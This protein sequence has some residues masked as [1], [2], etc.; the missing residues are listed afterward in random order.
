MSKVDKYTG[1]TDVVTFITKCELCCKVKGYTD[2]K[3][4]AFIAERLDDTAFD[5]YMSLSDAEKVNPTSVKNA[6]KANFRKAVK[7]R[8]VAVEELNNRKRLPN[9]TPEVFC[10]M[11]KELVK[12][13]YPGFTDRAKEQLAK[14]CYVKGLNEDTQRDLRKQP[15]YPTKALA[16]V[17]AA[18]NVIEIA[19]ANTSGAIKKEVIGGVNEVSSLEA[20]LDKLITVLTN[21]KEVKEDIEEEVNF[22]GPRGY[23][24]RGSRGSGGAGRFNDRRS[25]VKKCR[26]CDSPEYLYRKCPMR[27]CGACGQQGHD[28]WQSVCPKYK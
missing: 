13:A 17:V 12:L 19:E 22:A 11:I 1:L 14:D 16:D 7:N 26:N 25:S 9:E 10:Y 3:E 8:E 6:L 15:D 24:R 20:K 2:D 23:N 4:A 5:V 21:Q 28:G 27:Y 18:T